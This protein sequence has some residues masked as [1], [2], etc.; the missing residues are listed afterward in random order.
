MTD[1]NAEHLGK[2]ATLEEL[3][4][5]GTALSD[6]ADA[7]LRKLHVLLPDVKIEQSPPEAQLLE[8]LAAAGALEGPE[9]C[10]YG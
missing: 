4:S 7:Q 6:I 8:Q 2:P 5:N 1:A 9:N 10:A 3:A